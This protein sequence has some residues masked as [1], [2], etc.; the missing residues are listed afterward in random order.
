MIVKVAPLFELARVLNIVRCQFSRLH[1]GRG[2]NR[3]VEPYRRTAF[4]FQMKSSASESSYWLEGE[5]EVFPLNSALE[6]GC[7]LLQ[8]SRPSVENMIRSDAAVSGCWH[9]ADSQC[10]APLL[11]ARVDD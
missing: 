9:T 1:Y 10:Y 2:K 7:D 11:S 6:L 5:L 8:C 4:L 3:I